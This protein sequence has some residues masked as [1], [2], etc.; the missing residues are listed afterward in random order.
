MA[1]QNRKVY[2]LHECSGQSVVKDQGGFSPGYRGTFYWSTFINLLD[3]F[4]QRSL[5]FCSDITCK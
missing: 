5:V 2:L 4:D 1:I 3:T